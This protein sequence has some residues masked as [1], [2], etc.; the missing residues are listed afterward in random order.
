MKTK[1][2]SKRRSS[3]SS[4][5]TSTSKMKNGRLFWQQKNQSNISLKQLD[6][7]TQNGHIPID[8]NQLRNWGLSEPIIQYYARKGISRFFDWQIDCLQL[9]GVL[10]QQKNLVY[11]APTSAG[12][13]MVS[14]ILLFKTLL[15][16]RKKAI[17]IL[18]FVSI[19]MEKVQNLKQVFRRLG[20]R[21]DSFAGQT[22]PRGGLKRVDAAVCTIEKA[23]NMINRLIEERTISDIGLIIVD[24]LHMIGDQSRG[25][26]L[27]LLLSKLMHMK[28]NPLACNADDNIDLH[29][30]QIVG[31]SATIPNLNDIAKWLN[32]E[33]F[34]TDYRPVPLDEHVVV[35]NEILKI[36]SNQNQNLAD[37]QFNSCASTAIASLGGN[38]RQEVECQPLKTIDLNQLKLSTTTMSHSLIYLA[39]ETL[40][41][42]FSTL[43]FCPTRSMCESMAKTIAANIFNIGQKERIPQ[44]DF[45]SFI[46]ERIHSDQ[47]LS[48][49]RLVSLIETLKRSTS[50]SSSG[51]FDPNL[52]RVLRFGCA[53]H[54]AGMTMEERG[55]VEQGFRDGTLRILCCTTTLSAGVNL[56]ARRVMITSPFDYAN[57]LLPVGNYRQMIGRAGRKGIDILGES[58]LFCSD[59]DIRLARRLLSAEILPIKSNLVTVKKS[60]NNNKTN[61]SC[62]TSSTNS[63]QNITKKSQWQP[64]INDQLLRAVL[65]VIANEM[66]KNINDISG[67]LGCTFFRN[68]PL[69]LFGS[70]QQQQQSQTEE[71][72]EIINESIRLVLDRL[73]QFEFIYIESPDN[74]DSRIV[75]TDLGRAVISSG[76]SPTDGQ[77]IYE[78]LKRFRTKLSLLTDLHLVYQT[79]PVY[80][81]NQLPDIDWRHYLNLYERWDKNTKF[82]SQ[83]IGISEHFLCIQV[84]MSGLMKQTT[85]NESLIHRRFYAS[86]ALFDLIEEIPM[87]KVQQKYNLDKG[88]LQSL[89]QQASTF[90]GMLSTFCQRL[91]WKTLAK[92]FDEFQPR[93]SFGVQLDLIDLVRLPCV[94]SMIARQLFNKGYEDISSLINLKPKD[95][96]LALITSKD[97]IPDDSS[98]VDPNEVKIFLSTL[99]QTITITELSKMII[100]EARMLTEKEIGQK[101]S[102]EDEIESGSTVNSPVNLVVDQQP[103]Q[104]EEQEEEPALST[105]PSKMERSNE[106]IDN[107]IE[108]TNNKRI[109]TDIDLS[110]INHHHD[111]NDYMIKEVPIIQE[112]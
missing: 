81:V 11:S 89:Q 82:I 97:L 39:I 91:N 79:T 56:P 105:E 14:D 50:S 61:T 12:K 55:T 4:S 44:N 6:E 31:M 95:I 17:I 103:E 110:S 78:E 74:G 46:R 87:W 67:Y 8:K 84:S 59:K 54:H 27:E 62:S 106:S 102:F 29:Q 45:E 107:S 32:A 68:C 10:E 73:K 111:D 15:D 2:K 37:T 76:V 80:I 26:I 70:Q 36:S 20:L 41:Q 52:E 63:D 65:E 72:E 34:I 98:N 30:L 53:F 21:I 43:I 96:E 23:N 47:I 1:T 66:V 75:C 48:Y 83:M 57:N 18:P 86:L 93:L 88:T 19:S 7:T 33:L 94:N 112:G 108:S 64:I 22:N 25:Y 92:L 9:P 69:N 40:A 109:K 5:S 28:S 58:F 3:L 104:P 77:F 85:S 51:G 60:N 24:E 71:N 35:G 90:A 49:K 100:K 42:G 101:I 38:N 13:T 99:D 16:R